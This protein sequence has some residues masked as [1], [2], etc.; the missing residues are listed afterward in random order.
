MINYDLSTS[1][2]LAD[3]S[4][5]LCNIYMKNNIDNDDDDDNEDTVNL[6]ENLY[7]TETEF[8]NFIT[9]N[10]F[11]NHNNLTIISVNIANFLDF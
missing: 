11:S 3:D 8:L 7:Y 9:T 2:V 10:K 4:K 6:N 1:D 5:N